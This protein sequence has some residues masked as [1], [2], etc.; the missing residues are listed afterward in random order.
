MSPREEPTLAIKPLHP[1][2][3]RSIPYPRRMTTH[4]GIDVPWAG[5]HFNETVLRFSSSAHLDDVVDS[6]TEQDIFAGGKLGRWYPQYDRHLLVTTTELH[7]EEDLALL[8]RGLRSG[9]GGKT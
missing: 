8:T 4:A 2:L 9:R 5:P 7:T 6:L 3:G 1:E